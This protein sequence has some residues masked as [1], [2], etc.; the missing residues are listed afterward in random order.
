M[1]LFEIVSLVERS[2][3]VIYDKI[4]LIPEVQT[5]LLWR[6]RHNQLTSSAKTLSF[7]IEERCLNSRKKISCQDHQMRNYGFM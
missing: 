2:Q 7:K 6:L 5:M 1:L 3:R 4:I